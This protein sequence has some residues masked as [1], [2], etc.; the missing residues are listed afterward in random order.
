MEGPPLALRVEYDGKPIVPIDAGATEETLMTSRA[1][2]G[3][4]EPVLRIESPRANSPAV[5]L[6]PE[7]SHA[8]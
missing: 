4:H 1:V 5:S 8:R 3:I 6:P 2:Y 7:V